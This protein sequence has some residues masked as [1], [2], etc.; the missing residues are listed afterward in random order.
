MVGGGHSRSR[1]LQVQLGRCIR[2]KQSWYIQTT[3]AVNVI[4]CKYKPVIVTFIDSLMPNYC[5]LFKLHWHL[6]VRAALPLCHRSPCSALASFSLAFSGLPGC[7]HFIVD[8]WRYQWAGSNDLRQRRPLL[9]RILGGQEARPGRV[10]VRRRLRLQG[11]LGGGG[12]TW[13]WGAAVS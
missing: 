9:G 3:A 12:T 8:R 1:T 10:C 2:G 13:V 4:Q 7:P 6:C 5:V 11:A